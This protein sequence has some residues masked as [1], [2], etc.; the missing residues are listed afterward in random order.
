MSFHFRPNENFSRIVELTPALR[1]EIEATVERL[2]AILD[3]FDGDE[4]LEDDASGEPWLG[5]TDMEARYPRFHSGDDRE[6][7]DEH[8]GDILDEPHDG[9]E[10]DEEDHRLCE[11]V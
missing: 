2:I 9:G 11:Y 1:R 5:W 8:G 6:D 3:M 10:D 7:E 4:D